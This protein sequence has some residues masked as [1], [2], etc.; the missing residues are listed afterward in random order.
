MSLDYATY[1]GGNG[2]QSYVSAGA[3]FY[4]QYPNSNQISIMGPIYLPRVYGKDLTSFEIASS[5][6]V[7][8]TLYDIHSLDLTRVVANSNVII[9]TL[10]SDSL[11]MTVNNSNMSLTFDSVNNYTTLYSSNDLTLNTSNAL[12]FNSKAYEQSTAADMTLSA[13]CNMNIDAVNDVN[14]SACNDFAV[15]ADES[16]TLTA[17]SNSI[18]LDASSNVYLHLD[19]PTETATLFAKQDVLMTASNDFSINALS[20]V[21]VNATTASLAMSAASGDATFTLDAPTKTA[22]LFAQEDI[23]MTASND[24]SINALSNVTVNATTAS[25]AMSAASGDATFTLDAPTKTATLFAQED[26]NMTASNDFSINALSNVTVNATTASLAMSAASGDATFTL[27]APTKTATLFAM[28]DINMTA[29]NDFSINALSNVTVNATTASL[30]MSAASGDA[31]FT[32]DA[33]TKTATLF[34]MEDINMTASNDFSINALSNVTVNATTASLAMSAASGDATFT[35][36]A[37]TKTATLFAKEDIN[38]TASNDFSINA[39][40]NVTVNATTASLAMSAASGNATFTLDAPTKT[41][42][43]FAKEDINMTASNDL[44]VVAKSN[45]TVTAETQSLALSAVSGNVAFTMDAATMA[46]TLI[47]KSNVNLTASNDM[48]VVALRDLNI[49]VTRD[50]TQFVT[51]N[52]SNSAF[53]W[54][55]Y[56]ADTA[57]ITSSDGSAKLRLDTNMYAQATTSFDFSI[58]QNNTILHI[59]GDKVQILG[60][61]EVEGTIDSISVQQTVLQVQD[62]TIN[63]SHSSNLVIGDSNT[64]VTDGIAN[65]K[66]GIIVAGLPESVPQFSAASNEQY[67][68]KSILWNKNGGMVDTLGTSNF[69]AEPYWEVKGGALRLTQAANIVRDNNG[70]VVSSSN[71][72]FA[73]RIN[74]FSELEIVKFYG[75]GSAQRVAKFGRTLF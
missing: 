19:I 56:A 33:P 6:S 30:A 9:K 58:G 24:F 25:L 39:L 51:G 22:T 3:E 35:L 70:N 74:D 52:Y 29:S 41:A 10:D 17:L 15:V 53:N 34:A 43:L 72:S 50:L 68:G 1:A 71:V 59:D 46:A 67:F 42:T 2:T 44:S 64:Y 27:D 32:L 5:G 45:V 38:M 12:V 69:A 48:N 37:P 26:I 54:S 18:N 73:F 65:D 28:E 62:H 11:L 13:G 61:L 23:N 55:T 40:S 31:T 21:T 20:N 7:A 36:D 14:V 8:L 47:T 75:E 57:L 63:L 60:N 66:S 49:D 4:P 16:I